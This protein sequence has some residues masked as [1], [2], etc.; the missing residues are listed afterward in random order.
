MVLP[1]LLIWFIVGKQPLLLDPVNAWTWTL[2]LAV[3]LDLARVS[4]TVE[5]WATSSG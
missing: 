3:G 2:I 4:S 5:E 1:W